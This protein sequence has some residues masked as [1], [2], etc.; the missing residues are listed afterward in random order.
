MHASIY[1]TAK[2]VVLSLALVAGSAAQSAQSTRREGVVA[3]KAV[4]AQ[5]VSQQRPPA[6]QKKA[7]ARPDAT[8]TAAPQPKES[9]TPEPAERED[10]QAD[11][12]QDP[13]SEVVKVETDLVTVPVVVTDRDDAYVSDLK[14]EELTIQEDGKPQ[15]VV[16]F[17]TVS[18]PFDVVLMLDT[19]AS[20]QEK[21][22]LI[23]DA[24]VS[25]VEEL[26]REDRVKVISFDDK[27]VVQSEFSGDRVALAAAIRRTRP[28]K[29]TKLYDA[30]HEA[31]VS[32]RRTEK[33]RRRKA[34]VIFT[35]GVDWHSD[36]QRYAD[37]VRELEESGIIVYP[38]RFDTRAETEV[39]AREQAREQG[40]QIGDLS[41][42]FG[43]G[44][45]PRRGTTPSTVPDDGEGVRVG[46]PTVGRGGGGGGGGVFGLPIPGLP[47]RT[48]DPR[49]NPRPLPTPGGGGADGRDPASSPD[50]RQAPNDSVTR[51]LDEAYKLADNYLEDLANR[52]GGE[53]Y[54][55]G[56]LY[57][58][59]EVF[60][61]IAAELRTQYSLGYYPAERARDGRYRK[62]KV[63]TTRKGVSVRARP[64]YRA[65]RDPA[66][67]R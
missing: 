64:G 36:E 40:G 27:I 12:E 38:I 62:I 9:A 3:E 31:L 51:V 13:A 50:P 25:F 41:G 22:R 30:M 42:V 49:T 15:E 65:P 47:R 8:P 1:E 2:A 45:A 16:F 43:G 67:R 32:L 39:L 54:R 33:K 46:G 48:N 52:S 61:Q 57:S 28:G 66:A 59:S 44:G 5:S 55:A 11:E 58:L 63:A 18:E 23:Q 56:S 19:S 60:A 21:L 6:S 4:Q 10:V 29:G 17:A 20:A 34:A 14:R 35:D 24:A 26:G 37:N 53:L 7:A